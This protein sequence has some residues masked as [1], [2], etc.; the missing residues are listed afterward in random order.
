MANYQITG[1]SSPSGFNSGPYVDQGGGVWML[2]AGHYIIIWGG[3]FVCITTAASISNP[4]D[5]ACQFYAM[6]TDPVGAS[7]SAMYGS[8]TPVVT[9]AATGHAFTGQVTHADTTA[10]PGV[11]VTATTNAKSAVTDGSGNFSASLS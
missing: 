11:L 6:T 3:S 7:W 1:V 10:Y 2:D 4:G 9:L 5:P 8:G